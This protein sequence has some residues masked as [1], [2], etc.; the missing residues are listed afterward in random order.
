MNSTFNNNRA[1]TLMV[2]PLN[3]SSTGTIAGHTASRLTNDTFAFNSA[4]GGGG[5][6]WD[7]A[8][9]DLVLLNDTINNNTTPNNGGGIGLDGPDILAIQN[10]IIALNTAT[11]TGN[12]VF[13]NGS[14]QVTDN[15]GNFVG[16]LSGSNGFGGGTL[17]GNPHLGKLQ[18]NGGLYAGNAATRQISPTESLLP[19]SPA[20]AAGVASGSPSTDDR[21]FARPGGGAAKLAI[22]AYEPQYSTAATPNAVYVENLYEVLLNRIADPAGLANFTPQLNGGTPP[23]SVILEIEGSAEFL[24]DQA[25]LEYR[26]ISTGLPPRPSST[27][28]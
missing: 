17:T 14:L 1:A 21:G 19:G 23:S 15:G 13:T 8:D 2:G 24:A 20:I 5:A 12:D 9:G 6:I 26:A 18:D 28:S 7:F 10:T 16:T 22:G 25:R 27:A 3:L 11:G 4:Y